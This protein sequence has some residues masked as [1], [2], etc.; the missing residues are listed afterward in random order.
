MH[1]VDRVLGFFSSRSNW[2]THPTPSPADECFSPPPPPFGSGGDT[3]A[4][5][6]GRGGPNS[7]KGTETVVGTLGIYVLCAPNWQKVS[8]IHDDPSLQTTLSSIPYTGLSQRHRQA[9]WFLIFLHHELSYQK[10]Q[11]FKVKIM[12]FY[13]FSLRNEQVFN[14]FTSW[15]TVLNKMWTW[16]LQCP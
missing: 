13:Y 5:G 16:W 3:L 9:R 15:G 12:R 8:L 1:R 7:G 2:Y 10:Y 4:C 11:N 14:L 6:W